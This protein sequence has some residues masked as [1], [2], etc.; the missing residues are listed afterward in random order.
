LIRNTLYIVFIVWLIGCTSEKTVRNEFS[1]RQLDNHP[2]LAS[3]SDTLT[4]EEIDN[5]RVENLVVDSSYDEVTSQLLEAARQHY[6]SALDAEVQGDSIQCAN[7]FEYAIGILNELAYY[8]NIESNQDFNDL[9][10]SL[11]EDYERYIANIDSLGSET[12][13]FA[14]REKLNQ[15]DESNESIDDDTPRKIITTTTVPLVINGHVEQNIS[16]F[17]GKGRHHFEHWL[18]EGGKYFPIMKRIFKEEGIPEELVYLSMIESG[19]NPTAR[20]WAKAVGLWQFI[21]GTGRL[22]GLDGNFWYDERRDFEKSSKAAARH[23]KDL[24]LEFGDWYLALAAY[25]SG[26]GRVYRAIRKSGSTDFWKMRPYLPRETRNYVPQYIAVTVMALDPQSYGFDVVNSNSLD[27]EYVTVDGSIDLA[28]LAKCANTDVEIL[29][30]LNPELL[31][32]CTPPGLKEY[33]LRV[34]SGSSDVFQKNFSSIPDDQKKNWIVHK[35]KKRETLGS[36]AKRYGVTTQ[37]L[38]ESNNLHSTS[39]SAGKSL[40]VPIPVGVQNYASAI[41][42][43]N[44]DGPKKNKKAKY[45]TEVTS[46]KQKIVYR[47]RKGDSLGKIAEWFNVRISDLRRWNEIPYGSSI[48]AGGRLVVWVPDEDYEKYAKLDNLTDSEHSTLL[49]VD[50]SNSEPNSKSQHNSAY[51]IKYTVKEGDNLSKIAKNY[52]VAAEDIK[53]W[54]GITSSTIIVGQKLEIYI[55]ENGNLASSVS[56]KPQKGLTYTVKKGDTLEKIASSFGV[57]IEQLRIWNKLRSSKIVIGQE[58]VINT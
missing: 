4:R 57:T 41:K 10:R 47:I 14:L 45:L 16:F 56:K 12:S 22:Y 37:M 6:L 15:I 51:W 24:Y 7:E 3:I 19:L 17:Q 29:K 2:I 55:D 42:A 11:V 20:S 27:Y 25:N 18:A 8:P 38:M 36:I 28:T 13:I 30:D 9:T 32:S 34:P 52:G 54:N 39:I 50:N 48:K 33:K 23:L 21:K 46:G 1:N 58:L 40:I 53:K 5:A 35:V 49:T 43:E 44:F 31:K 26:A